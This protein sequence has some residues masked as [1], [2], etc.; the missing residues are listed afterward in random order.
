MFVYIIMY[1]CLFI[2]H[3]VCMF[4]YI[5]MYVCL[6]IHYYVCLFVYSL[7]CMY[8]MCFQA[9]LNINELII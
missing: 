6:F 2:H 1:V 9:L 8:G 3:Y 7:L 5:I 4:A